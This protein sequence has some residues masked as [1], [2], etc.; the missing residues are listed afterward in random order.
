MMIKNRI[1]ILQT[2]STNAKRTEQQG[3]AATSTSSN[4]VSWGERKN[5]MDRAERQ[6][7]ASHRNP[8]ICCLPDTSHHPCP[9][10][11]HSAADTSTS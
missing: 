3:A 11:V 2:S 6:I 8:P 4:S 7:R 10:A 1:R 9:S 5:P